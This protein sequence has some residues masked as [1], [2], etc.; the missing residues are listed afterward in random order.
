MYDHEQYPNLCAEVEFDGEVDEHLEVRDWYRENGEFETTTLPN[1]EEVGILTH[2]E[3][4]QFIDPLSLYMRM[5]RHFEDEDYETTDEF[6]DA[7]EAAAVKAVEIGG[8]WYPKDIAV[9]VANAP[10]SK[11]RLG[12]FVEMYCNQFG[13]WYS[14]HEEDVKREVNRIHT[15]LENLY[16]VRHLTDEMFEEI[17]AE[18]G[19]L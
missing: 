2:P 5:E 9:Q 4:E 3:Y 8:K 6:A 15:A 7:L 10:T 12:S 11:T 17:V 19:I 18:H 1:L 16:G 13:V 14:M